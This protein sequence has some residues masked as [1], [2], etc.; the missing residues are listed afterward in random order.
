[1]KTKAFIYIVVAG[2]LWG[3]SGIFVHYMAP[4]GFSSF[5]ITAVRGIV[6]FV[7]MLLF[8]L[9]KNRSLLK[10]TWRQLLMYS[11]CGLCLYLTAA[12]YYTSMQLTSVSTA[13][14]LMD[15][16]PIYVAVVSVLFFGER[17]TKMKLFSVIGMLVGCILV[18]GVLTGLAFDVWGILIGVIS[19][20]TYAGYNIF[21]KLSMRQGG[22]PMSLTVYA[23]L[24]MALIA[25]V[26]TPPWEIVAIAAQAP[27]I[28]V[29]LCIGIGVVTF[30]L[31]YFLYTMALGD[32]PAGT[33]S[34]L[35]IVE[36]MAATVF[37][38][39]FLGETIGWLSWTGIALI[40][41]ST[42]LLSR[43]KS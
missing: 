32:L 4:Y 36:P 7:G 10:V 38:V 11:V 26:V 27:M 40:L 31:P 17:F 25:C 23:F 13:V 39:I 18:S 41:L 1:M 33:A 29:P 22:N 2:L 28:T 34:A 12:L 15:M 37:S 14:V 5:Q 35:S 19:G 20:F 8:V 3:T 21:T 6:S 16:A 30:I 43:E 24:T 9:L 42:V